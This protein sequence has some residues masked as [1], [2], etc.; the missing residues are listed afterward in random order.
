ML[1]QQAYLLK[2]ANANDG[3]DSNHLTLLKLYNIAK[4][5]SP[6]A[7]PAPVQQE[8]V[9]VADQKLSTTQVPYVMQM[10]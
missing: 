10:L 8:K 2:S 9:A 6:E 4:G 5:S 3:K 7:K 1:P